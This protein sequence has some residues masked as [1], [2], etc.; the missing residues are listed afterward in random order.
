MLEEHPDIG[1]VITDINMPE[2]N[3]W[4]LL[5]AL[6]ELWPAVPSMV[7]SAYGNEENERRAEESGAQ[8]FMAKPVDFAELREK[9]AESLES[10]SG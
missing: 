2:M 5:D 10:A 1:L 7:V 4:Q 6:V 9:V 3:A 8:G